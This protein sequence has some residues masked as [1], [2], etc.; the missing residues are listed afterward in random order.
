MLEAPAK[1]VGSTIS[2][3]W[4]NPIPVVIPVNS[5]AK[6]SVALLMLN[7]SIPETW[8]PISPPARADGFR[9]RPCEG[10]RLSDKQRDECH[11]FFGLQVCPG[12]DFFVGGKAGRRRARTRTIARQHQDD[13]VLDSRSR[14][15]FQRTH[16]LK[17]Q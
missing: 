12:K 10:S 9:S 15:C 2:T 17:S 11:E 5:R 1:A 16:A 6:Q 13:R 8:P 4:A 3:S 7:I 14:R